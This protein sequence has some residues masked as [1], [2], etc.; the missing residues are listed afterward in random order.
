MK[1]C[2]KCRKFNEKNFECEEFRIHISSTL[3]ATRCSKY[4]LDE[5]KERKLQSS[6]QSKILKK[7]Y[8][9]K[10]RAKTCIDCESN[11]EGYCNK[12]KNWC[13]KVNYICLG[14]KNPNQYKPPKPRG[15]P[16]KKIKKKS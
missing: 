15:K 7:D 12:H 11:Q 13:G 2:K 1:T 10:K 5:E 16:K 9:K 14:I 4:K 8:Q 6:K 3:N